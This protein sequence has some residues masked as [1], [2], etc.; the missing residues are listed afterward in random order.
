MCRRL[1]DEMERDPS[2]IGQLQ[3]VGKA[4][5]SFEI[6]IKDFELAFEL[7]PLARPNLRLSCGC[8]SFLTLRIS[9]PE[10]GGAAEQHHNS[11]KK[12]A[13]KHTTIDPGGDLFSHETTFCLMVSAWARYGEIPEVQSANRKDI[14]K[15]ISK[16]HGLTGPLPSER[17]G[18]RFEK[19]R[20]EIRR[21]RST[22]NH[23]RLTA[24]VQS[25]GHFGKA[26]CV[27][28][29][30]PSASPSA[31]LGASAKQG[32]LPPAPF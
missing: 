31:S 14:S 11:Q 3:R 25:A 19:S 21:G 23:T 13:A 22:S 6:L 12:R 16:G 15:D 29:G 7:D 8:G 17:V 5:L 2:A 10:N 26:A 9:L 1:L 24:G 28:A 18:E 4:A 20:L 27:G 32:R 30:A